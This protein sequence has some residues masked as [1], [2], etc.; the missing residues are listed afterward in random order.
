MDSK[1]EIA[2]ITVGAMYVLYT[3]GR[4][5]NIFCLYR[6][7]GGQSGAVDGILS[8]IS[9]L[10]MLAGFPVFGISMLIGQFDARR[11][12]ERGRDKQKELDDMMLGNELHDA[13]RKGYADGIR[14]TDVFNE[15]NPS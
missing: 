11:A 3:V 14:G 4:L 9:I 10:L 5:I 12:E 8:L 1:I 6:E 2:L 15:R 13:Y 7:D